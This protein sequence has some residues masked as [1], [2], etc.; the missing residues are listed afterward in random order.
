MQY[1]RRNKIVMWNMLCLQL[2]TTQLLLIIFIDLLLW[3]TAAMPTTK[4]MKMSCW[5][6]KIFKPA[7]S[8]MQAHNEYKSFFHINSQILFPHHFPP[9]CTFI[10]WSGL[11]FFPCT[12]VTR[13]LK[14]STGWYDHFNLKCKNRPV[15]RPSRWIQI[16][17]K[18]FVFQ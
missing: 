18:I 3:I 1:W 12:N 5:F 8:Q 2:P 15:H 4:W 7:L 14:G 17:M 9:Q 16:D 10:T 11:M 6:H 13:V